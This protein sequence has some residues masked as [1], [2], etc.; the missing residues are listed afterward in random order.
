MEEHRAIR[1]LARIMAWDDERATNEFAWLDMMARVKYDGYRDFLAGM[2]FLESLAAW[3][4]QF[5]PKDRETAYSLLRRRLIY[6]GPA[7][8]QRLVELFFPTTL[9]RHLIDILA[10]RHD[11]P[12][13]KVLADK[14]LRAELKSLRRRTLIMGLSDGARIDIL[15][16][17][18]VGILTNEQFVIQTQVDPPKW[19]DLLKDL[20]KS[21]G[22]DARFEVIYLVDDFM[23]SGSSFVRYDSDKSAWTGK[24]P[25]FLTSLEPVEQDVVQQNWGLCVHHY[26]ATE[27]A[28]SQLPGV[29]A[30]AKEGRPLAQMPTVTF[31]AVIPSQYGIVERRAE[32][33]PIVELT[34][35]YYNP[36]IQT[37]HTL[38]GGVAHL[39]LGYSAC[40]LPLVLEH[41]T[42]NNSLAILWAEA[43]PATVEG[44]TYREM[45]PLFRRRQRHS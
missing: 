33:A 5:E 34:Q 28:Q 44:I 13:Y 39:G 45:R 17:S 38:K 36:S 41:N 30:K 42:P 40:A 6:I 11:V 1:I 25:R 29:L 8:M 9:Q 12:H 35:T 10:K 15:R 37:E 4:Q 7:E 43:D 23:G 16:H 21:E 19:Y 18:T 3:L 20:R 24:L 22:S 31:G 32:D 2:R 26:L 14:G 27:R